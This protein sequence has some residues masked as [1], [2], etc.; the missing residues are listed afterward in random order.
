MTTT[1]LQPRGPIRPI[2]WPE[3]RAIFGE[4]F[5]SGEHWTLI[6]HGSAVG[7]LI[8]IEERH[9][10]GDRNADL[11]VMTTFHRGQ[12]FVIVAARKRWMPAR[13]LQSVW[14]QFAG[15]HISELDLLSRDL[16]ILAPD[17]AMG[18]ADYL[19]VR[20]LAKDDLAMAE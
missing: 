14:R 18:V 20:L 16:L 4:K 7:L 17:G 5:S 11:T 10:L 19:A 2:D 1:P 13:Q 6:L 8:E 9:Y 15:A 3:A 12:P